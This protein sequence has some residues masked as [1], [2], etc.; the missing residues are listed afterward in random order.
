MNRKTATEYP[1]ELWSLF[2]KYIH[3]DI[4]RRTFLGH[5]QKFLIAGV[6][7]NALWDSI[8]PNY[9]WAIQVPKDDKR[10]KTEEVSVDSPKGNGKIKGH[11][12]RPAKAGKYPVVLVV[13]ENRGLIHISKMWPVV[14]RR[15]DSSH[16][17]QMVG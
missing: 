8:R 12:A 2:D 17:L 9:A 15:K 4:D 10:I 16:W 6:T 13:H 7:L 14:W 5:A 1:Q 3:G 11:L